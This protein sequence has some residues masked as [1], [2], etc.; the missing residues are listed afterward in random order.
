MRRFALELMPYDAATTTWEQWVSRETSKRFVLLHFSYHETTCGADFAT[1]RLLYGIFI[2]SSLMT[3]TYGTAPAFS[4]TQDLDI[5]ILDEECLWEAS[6]SQQWETLKKSQPPRSNMT[7]RDAM[8]HLIYGKEEP[9]AATH[10]TKWT[11]FATTM[12]FHAVNVNMWNVMQ[13]TQSFTTFAVDEQNSKVLKI[14]LVSQVE[15]SLA[16]CYALLTADRSERDH[17]SDDPEGPLMFNCLALLR[18]AY[19]RVFTEAGNFNRMMLLSE[20]PLQVV[21]T[22]TDP[23]ATT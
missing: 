5:E 4:V 9:A 14:A 13:C 17:T 1:A 2:M 22:Y 6:T 11:A 16:R 15:T 12:V 18:S 3:V 8:T 19:V 7:V 10:P 21:R 20:E 23:Y